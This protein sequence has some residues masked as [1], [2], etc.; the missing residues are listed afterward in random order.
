MLPPYRVAREGDA[1][2]N[3]SQFTAVLALNGYIIQVS[4]AGMV[5]FRKWYADCCD[6]WR[7]KSRPVVSLIRF[8]RPC[9]EEVGVCS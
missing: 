3:A 7:L 8:V 4:R 6:A 1:A 9:V 5:F 2:L